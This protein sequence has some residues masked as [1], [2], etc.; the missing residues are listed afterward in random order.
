MT[1]FIQIRQLGAGIL[2]IIFEPVHAGAWSFALVAPS[3]SQLRLP[4][5]MVPP[6][7]VSQQI[8]LTFGQHRAY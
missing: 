6:A 8:L 4:V 7:Q 1:V 3:I 5:P 2:K